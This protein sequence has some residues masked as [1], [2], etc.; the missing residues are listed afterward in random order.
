ML[1]RNPRANLPRRIVANVLGVRAF[2]VRNPMPFSILMKV[3]D[4]AEGHF[5]GAPGP[6]RISMYVDAGGNAVLNPNCS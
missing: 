4:S 3:D 5:G 6:G 1:G 2:E